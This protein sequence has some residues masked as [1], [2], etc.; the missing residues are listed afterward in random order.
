MCTNEYRNEH[1][2][3]HVILLRID[4]LQ[5]QKLLRAVQGVRGKGRLG[6]LWGSRPTENMPINLRCILEQDKKISIKV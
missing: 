1:L 2:L 6:H 4:M 3:L 5:P